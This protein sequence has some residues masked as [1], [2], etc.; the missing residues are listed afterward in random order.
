MWPNDNRTKENSSLYLKHDSDES[1]KG[2]A[3]NLIDLKITLLSTYIVSYK[4]HMS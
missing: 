3:I 4:V 2:N 1:E